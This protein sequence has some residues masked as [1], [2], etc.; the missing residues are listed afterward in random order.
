MFDLIIYV[1][2][3]N[4][5]VM[6]KQVFLGWTSTKQGLM[7]L[8]QGHNAVTLVRLE[9]AALQSWVKHSTTETVSMDLNPAIQVDKTW[10]GVLYIWKN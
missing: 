7:C 6:Y 5:S 10:E 3:N 2:V 1:P 9:P 8:A 4:L